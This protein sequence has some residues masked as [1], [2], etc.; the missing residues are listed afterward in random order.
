MFWAEVSCEVSDED[1]EMVADLLRLAGAGGVAFIGP[2]L[3]RDRIS[4]ADSGEALVFPESMCLDGPLRVTAYFPVDDLLENRVRLIKEALEEKWAREGGLGPRP[5]LVLSQIENS[6]WATAWKSYYT[7]DHVG[8]RVVIVPSWVDYSPDRGEVVILLDPG[9]AFGTGQHESTRGAIR[10]IEAHLE[11][12]ARLLDVGCGSGIL[13]I[14]AA[15]LGASMVDGVD[16]DSVAVAVA[17][18]NVDENQVS[19][20][21]AIN[22]G[23]LASGIT[24]RYDVVVANILA[25]VVA[26][27][28]R[29]LPR[30]LV[31]GG[32][33]ISSGFVAKQEE[34]VRLALESA[35]H[36]II[37]RLQLE[38]WVTLVSEG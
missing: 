10:A 29:D 20:R 34:C 2:S 4:S 8:E 12:S 36:T 14:V 13:S 38:E 5:A 24:G 18:S 35:G 31:P 37:D 19:D 16:N 30:L 32:K 25:D 1:S 6:N 17:R 21:V 27:L 22:L 23:D 33:C 7:V 15:K 28:A 26:R 9:E 11:P 3:I